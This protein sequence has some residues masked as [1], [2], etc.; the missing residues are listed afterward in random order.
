M[1]AGTGITITL[2]RRPCRVYSGTEP[3][4][5]T[6]THMNRLLLAAAVAILPL[7]IVHPLNAQQPAA[8]VEGKVSARPAPA[9]R[10]PDRYNT[11]ASARTPAALPTVVYIRGAVPGR[12]PRR[13]ARTAEMI[14]RDTAFMPAALI[15]PVGS[16]VAFQNRDDF[17][18]NVF[19]YSR[20]K[21]FDLGRYPSPESKTVV[22]DEAGVV[23]VYC[24]I[25][26]F[27]RAAILVV[28]NPFHAVVDADGG[29]CIADVPPGR[30]TLVA[31]H[32]DRGQKSMTIDVPA[33]GTVR[34]AFAF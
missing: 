5:R 25:H 30:Y 14:Q 23:D 29:F 26:K 34:A 8:V 28:E 1:G 12:P 31:L 13:S 16:S 15:V 3:D 2:V 19:S 7:A 18:H 21:R 32:P 11:G 24:E 22:F 9:F 20:A 4:P 17:F 6:E 27:M 33:S 10:V